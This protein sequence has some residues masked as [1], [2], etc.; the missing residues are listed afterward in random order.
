[1]HTPFEQILLNRPTWNVKCRVKQIFSIHEYN[2]P[3]GTGWVS[4]IILADEKKDLIQL[5]LFN[6]DIQRYRDLLQEDGFFYINNL[7]SKAVNLEYKII[8]HDYQLMPTRHTNIVPFD[9]DTMPV[10]YNFTPFKTTTSHPI[11]LIDILGILLYVSDICPVKTKNNTFTLKRDLILIDKSNHPVILTF[12][13]LKAEG[14]TADLVHPPIFHTILMGKSVKAVEYQGISL[15]STGYTDISINPINMGA[16]RLSTW[17]HIIESLLHCLLYTVLLFCYDAC[18]LCKR[19]INLTTDTRKCLNCGYENDHTIPSYIIKVNVAD[20][21]GSIDFA[22][23]TDE[24]QHILGL[25]ATEFKSQIVEANNMEV[26]N[27]LFRRQVGEKYVF[28]ISAERN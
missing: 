28:I 3:H 26:V 4:T 14:I 6:E 21:S 23:F 24:A 18:V 19:K 25:S 15:S 7:A 5:I 9:G 8:N 22:L 17:E 12:W 20:G 16:E 11:G 1:M 2:R 10:G 27:R 13:G